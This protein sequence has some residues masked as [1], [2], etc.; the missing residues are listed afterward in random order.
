MKKRTGNFSEVE[1]TDGPLSNPVI[2]ED[3]LPRPDQLVF[4]EEKI[5]VTINLNDSCVRF[6]K[7]EA[8]RYR[9]PYQKLIRSVLDTFVRNATARAD[10]RMSAKAKKVT[11]AKPA[12][13]AAKVVK[14]LKGASV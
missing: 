9:T 1:Y 10:K 13:K 3:N 11:K 14:V 2:I 4:T 7:G 6:F 12:G 5:R 8:K